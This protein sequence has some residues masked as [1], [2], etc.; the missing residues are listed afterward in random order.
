MTPN[1]LM[2]AYRRYTIVLRFRVNLERAALCISTHFMAHVLI[3]LRHTHLSILQDEACCVLQRPVSIARCVF[4]IP[5]QK[6]DIIIR[7]IADVYPSSVL[8][9]DR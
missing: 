1:T 5:L 4:G 8:M 3:I 2:F 7:R 9:K 6:S